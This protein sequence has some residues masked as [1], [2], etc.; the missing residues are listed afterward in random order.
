MLGRL[1]A[2][3]TGVW[4]LL[5]GQVLMNVGF[6][7]LI[8][9]LAVRFTRDLG[10]DATVAGLILGLRMLLQQCS[11]PLGGALSDRVGYKP[12]IVAGFVIRAL[13]FGLFAVTDDVVGALAGS[14]V[15]AFGGALFEPPSRAAL[16]YLTTERE[17]AGVY[18]SQGA[19]SWLGQVIGPL[20]GAVL[21]PYSFGAVCAAA[22]AAFLVASLQGAFFL[23]GAMRGE[24][25]NYTFL[26]SILAAMRDAEFARFTGLLLLF[27]F[28]SVQ[29]S[30]TV[31]LLTNQVAGAGAIGVIFALQ[32]GLAMV[33]QV[34]LTRLASR[35]LGPMAQIALA[36][37]IM[38]LG[39]VGF[40]GATSLAAIAVCTAV[41]AIAQ[42]LMMPT[43]SLITARMAGGQ[44]G[45]YFGVGAMALGLGGGSGQALGGLLMDAGSRAS[46]PWLPWGTMAVLAALSAA[47]FVWL[48]TQPSVRRRLGLRVGA[49]EVP[50][51]AAR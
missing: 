42:L 8:P 41:V 38:A 46:M 1:P 51:A 25:G 4:S 18:A 39:F 14:V 2:Y 40:M 6:Y 11:A 47:G 50:I 9:L 33:L 10:L 35:Y 49:S 17:R 32:A 21:L 24:V 45:A 3:S 48:N 30:I 23:P 44:G 28:G 27:F 7:M 16:A 5:L 36:A 43:Q 19:M 15:M 31:P 12:V 22:A 34:P 29:M 37:V 13:S 26:G 20:L